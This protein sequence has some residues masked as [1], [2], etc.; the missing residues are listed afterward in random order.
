MIMTHHGE[1]LHDPES[2]GRIVLPDGIPRIACYR[3]LITSP[4]FRDME[5]FSDNFLREHDYLRNQYKWVQDP[6]HQWSRQWEYPWVSCTVSGH[7]GTGQPVHI[8]DAGSGITFFPYYLASKD[9]RLEVTCC[10]SDTTLE[11]LFARV[12]HERN[13]GDS[14]KFT[15][16]D[17]LTLPFANAYFDVIYCVSVLEH[18]QNYSRILDEF[19]R[20]L[21]PRGLLALTFDIGLDN[22][23]EITPAAAHALLHEVLR[24]FPTDSSPEN[25]TSGAPDLL[26]SSYAIGLNSRLIPWKY[27]RLALLKAAWRA[28]RIPNSLHKELTVYCGGF[29]A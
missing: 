8:L 27:P 20:V 15:A 17:L 25:I 26:T 14:I 12:N 10:D 1:I 22:V 11:A 3:E 9:E 13:T 4:F 7:P 24:R 6:L 28:K 18:T 19:R 2:S 29:G 16:A 23:S 21:K 5:N